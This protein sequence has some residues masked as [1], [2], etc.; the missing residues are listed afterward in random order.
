MLYSGRIDVAINIVFIFFLSSL[1]H[2]GLLYVNNQEVSD[3]EILMANETYGSLGE[4]AI[5][6]LP[7]QQIL[8]LFKKLELG[9]ITKEMSTSEDFLATIKDA[10]VKEIIA[11]ESLEYH[12]IKS[13]S[14]T[15]LTQRA[16]AGELI[17]LGHSVFHKFGRLQEEWVCILPIVIHRIL[18][19]YQDIQNYK[20]GELGKLEHSIGETSAKR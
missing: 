19:Q 4:L 6:S 13:G 1:E 14:E 8:T 9:D 2:W 11:K 18:A 10:N 17:Q 20:K 16:A 3:D 5:M 7:K 15:V 12:P